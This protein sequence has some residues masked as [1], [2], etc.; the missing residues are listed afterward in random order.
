MT[1]AEHRTAIK[2]AIEAVWEENLS[3]YEYVQS[4]TQVPA[5][6]ITPASEPTITFNGAFGRGS[7]RHYYD[8]I[9]LAP[10]TEATSNQ[11]TLDTL[12]DP[13]VTNS[14]PYILHGNTSLGGNVVACSCIRVDNYGGE[15]PSANIAHIGALVRVEIQTCL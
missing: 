5:V 8:V 15:W 11:I 4:V 7:A 1:I 2:G 14:I 12:V 9:C 3:V 10:Q 13:D 6:V